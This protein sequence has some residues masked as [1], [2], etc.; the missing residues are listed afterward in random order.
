MVS[1]LLQKRVVTV[2]V[3]GLFV[4]SHCEGRWALGVV[5]ADVVGVVGVTVRE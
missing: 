2:S 5:S 1:E 4:R 3:L